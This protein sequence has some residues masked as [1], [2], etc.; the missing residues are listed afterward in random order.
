MMTVIQVAMLS[1]LTATAMADAIFTH[2][3][4]GG[5]PQH[6]LRNVRRLRWPTVGTGV[7]TGH[8]AAHL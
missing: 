6:P 2:P 5:R 7:R 4:S 8:R 3:A 1:K